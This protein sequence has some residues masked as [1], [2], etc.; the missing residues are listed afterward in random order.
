MILNLVAPK[1]DPEEELRDTERREEELEDVVAMYLRGKI[2][3]KEFLTRVKGID[4]R[5][6]LRRAGDRLAMPNS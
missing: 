5:L 6:D 2:D 1:L 4:A 3:H